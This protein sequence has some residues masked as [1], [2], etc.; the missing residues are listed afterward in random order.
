V[1]H[2]VVCGDTPVVPVSCK[3]L[4]AEAQRERLA[5]LEHRDPRASGR[6]GRWYSSTTRSPLSCPTRHA[7]V[8]KPLPAVTS[9]KPN[10]F[11]QKALRSGIACH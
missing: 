10:I 5:G 9:G 6:S 11:R 3:L 4:V 2:L 8:I 7:Y 1:Q